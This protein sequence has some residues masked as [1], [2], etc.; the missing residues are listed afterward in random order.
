M[1]DNTPNQAA[2]FMTEHWVERNDD[3]RGTYNIDKK[4]KLKLQ[5]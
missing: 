4:I 2:K 5:C 3:A 1:L